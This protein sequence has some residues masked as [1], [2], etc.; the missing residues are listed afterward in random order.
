MR[1]P[2]TSPKHCRLQ[3]SL[4]LFTSHR[5]KARVNNPGPPTLQQQDQVNNSWA[6]PQRQCLANCKAGLEASTFTFLHG[7]NLPRTSIQV[8][9]NCVKCWHDPRPRRT[10]CHTRSFY[11]RQP[12]FSTANKTPQT[13]PQTTL[14]YFPLCQSQCLLPQGLR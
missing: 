4:I 5:I 3:A 13:L 7:T 1:G 6:D 12:Y 14:S 11:G 9:N 8:L 2:H 10:P